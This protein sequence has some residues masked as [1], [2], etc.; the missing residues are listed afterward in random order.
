MSTIRLTIKGVTEEEAEILIA[1]LDDMGFEGFEQSG[2]DLIGYVR[3]QIFRKGAAE[4]MLRSRKLGFE[5]ADVEEKNWNKEWE[6]SF[7]PVT[8]LSADD[9]VP[10]VHVRASFHPPFGQAVHELEIN[11]K[12]SFGTGHHATTQLM[13]QA[14]GRLDMKDK[15]VVDFGTGTGILAVLAEKMG[16]AQILATDCD[17]GCMENAVE[18][19]RLNRCSRIEWLECDV[20]PETDRPDIILANINLNVIIKNLP[21][22]ANMA[23]SGTEI[24][25]SGILKINED[26]LT[27]KL[28]ESEIEIKDSLTLGDW[29]MIHAYIS[30]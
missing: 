17:P 28:N 20:F 7:Q 2:D 22:I 1:L 11:P 24:L 30:R 4:E 3:E 5:T 6:S 8:I 14:M 15:K 27:M 21:A 13:M 29:I 9:G 26:Q 25:L 10:M 16:A 12:M 19:F 18:N 23:A